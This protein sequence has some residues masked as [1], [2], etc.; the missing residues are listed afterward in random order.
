MSPESFGAQWQN[1]TQQG[2][3]H[4]EGT[5]KKLAMIKF[6]RTSALIPMATL[7]ALFI[8]PIPTAVSAAYCAKHFYACNINADGSLDPNHPGCCLGVPG[9]QRA[10][11]PGFYACRYNA[12]G[13]RD[14]AHPGC[15]LNV[16]GIPHVR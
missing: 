2:R 4:W 16:P 9:F 11:S 13:Y 5:V 15:C 10:C 6:A 1:T 12:G 8:L 7:V 14:A 3:A